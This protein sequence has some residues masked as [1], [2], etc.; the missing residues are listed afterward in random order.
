MYCQ[1]AINDNEVPTG[2]GVIVSLT[3][4]PGAIKTALSNVP[5]AL[6]IILADIVVVSFF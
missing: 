6:N 1:E 4:Q 2:P 5:F 3:R